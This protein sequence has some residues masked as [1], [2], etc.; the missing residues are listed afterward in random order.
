MNR[1][2]SIV[3]LIDPVD[4]LLDIGTD[5]GLVIIEAFLQKK[6]NQAI[7][8]DINEG[9]LKSAYENIKNENFQTKTTFLQTDGFFGINQKYDGVVITGVGYKT[10]EHILKMPHQTPKYYILGAQSQLEELRLF[11]SSNN[12]KI[13]D[14]LIYYNKRDYVFI[15]IIKGKQKLSEKELLLGPILMNKKEALNYYIKQLNSLNAIIKLVNE[16]DQT[17]LQKQIDFYEKVIIKLKKK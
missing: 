17:K 13:I 6:I 8:S 3:S 11:L 7:A 5:H 4:T 14:E 15:K 10:I 9:P 12:F 2:K 16:S 1:I